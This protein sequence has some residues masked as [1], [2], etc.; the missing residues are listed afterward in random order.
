MT[1]TKFDTKARNRF[2]KH[3]REYGLLHLAAD[4]AGVTAETIRNHRKKSKTFAARYE[5]TLEMFRDEVEQEAHR[6]AT[7]GVE[8]DHYSKDGDYTHTVTKYSDR[9]MET[10]LKRHR[11]EYR[12]KIA[13]EATVAGGVLVLPHSKMTSKEWEAD[14]PE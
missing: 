3:F 12:D 6:R 4:A 10:I 9:L 13:V 5:S 7:K 2:F 14:E 11:P 8:T 1:S